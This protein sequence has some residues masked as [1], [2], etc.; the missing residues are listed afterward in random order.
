[1][2]CFIIPGRIPDLSF[3]E[4]VST[5]SYLKITYTPLIQSEKLFFVDIQTDIKGAIAFFKRLGGS[6]KMGIIV[7]DPFSYIEQD[8]LHQ[9]EVNEKL[10]F[11]VSFYVAGSETTLKKQKTQLGMKF[12]NWLKESSYKPRFVDNPR[13]L[14]TPSVLLD[15]NHVLEKGFELNLLENPKTHQKEWGVTIAVQ[16]Y[17]GFSIRDYDRP[18]SNK[19]KGMVP[20]KLARIMVNL[21]GCEPG[22]TIWD[23]FCGS[24]TILQEAL[25]L[26]YKVI[27]SDID[28][29]SILET[30]TNLEW[31]CETFMISHKNYE[32]FPHDV[33]EGIP[34]GL[35]FDAIVTEP[36]LGPVLR[37]E[38]TVQRFQEIVQEVD[39]VYKALYKI[40]EDADKTTKTGVV[41]VPGFK[42]ETG[43]YDFDF[44]PENTQK[45]KEI[46][47]QFSK[48]GLQWSRPNSIIRRNLKIFEF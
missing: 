31:L 7:D 13:E 15:K 36:F 21:A 40:M 47:T 39:P 45:V 18:K 29:R 12:K 2:K 42:T 33:K 48:K 23:P 5:L 24:G 32:I 26:G 25:L 37:Q 22:S 46:T 11:S 34:K 16:D 38:I 43:W 27:G 28:H 4:I 9:I 20:P 10:P 3:A 41:V 8:L 6:I 1:M 19:F 35:K 30:K 14:V 44:A 17:E